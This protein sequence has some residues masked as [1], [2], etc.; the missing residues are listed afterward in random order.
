LSISKEKLNLAI[1]P[2]LKRPNIAKSE[3]LDTLT[4]M[5]NVDERGWLLF[6]YDGRG[7]SMVVNHGFKLYFWMQKGLEY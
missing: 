2:L 3:S 5:Y 4:R 6:L 1:G 7:A